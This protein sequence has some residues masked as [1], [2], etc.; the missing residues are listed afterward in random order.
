[1]PPSSLPDTQTLVHRF[2]EALATAETSLTSL[3]TSV[4]QLDQLTQLLASTTPQLTELVPL[5]RDLM[6][7]ADRLAQVLRPSTRRTW[8]QATSVSLAACVVT[9]VALTCLR[10][11]W[12]LRPDQARQL[13]LGESIERLYQEMPA[14]RRS[15]LLELLDS[16][17]SRSLS[18]KP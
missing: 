6:Q 5:P 7:A 11:Q 12:M 14:S 4:S 2:L 10:P 1:M 3:S 9:V 17:S 16:S 8:L 18:S 13:W 15:R